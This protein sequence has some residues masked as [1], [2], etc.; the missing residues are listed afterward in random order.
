MDDV[1][2]L[3]LVALLADDVTARTTLDDAVEVQDVHIAHVVPHPQQQFPR[4]QS[5]AHARHAPTRTQRDVLA[6]ERPRRRDVQ[7]R[8]T[9]AIAN[10]AERRLARAAVV[11]RVDARPE[12]FDVAGKRHLVQRY[13]PV[14]RPH[15]L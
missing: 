11:R 12:A 5:E 9:P 6:A 8:T 14:G 15:C 3:S 1:A 4:R 2:Q 13:P 10:A 7:R